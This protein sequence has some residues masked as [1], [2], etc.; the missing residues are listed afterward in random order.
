MRL[1]FTARNRGN[2][3]EN[4]TPL[5]E[6]GLQAEVSVLE[7]DGTPDAPKKISVSIQNMQDKAWE[8]VIVTELLANKK[9]PEFF[10]PGF[11]YGSNRGDCPQ[12][13]DCEY[14]RMREGGFQRP[15]S[16]FWMMRGDRLS[17]PVALIYDSGH[18]TGI[19]GN[20]YW[21]YKNGKKVPMPGKDDFYQYAGY[22]CSLRSNEADETCSVGYTL[23]YENAPLLFVQS[24]T[25]LDREPLGENCFALAAGETVTFELYVFEYEAEDATGIHKA[26]KKVYDLFHESPRKGSSVKQ[27]VEDLS[28]AIYRCSYLPEQK[29]Y[30]LFVR[31]GKDG[32]Y[33]YHVLGSLSWTN[34]LSVAVPVLL[35]AQ[36][37]QD[38]KMRTQAL[39][40][41]GNILDNCM[42]P[43]S[44]LPYDAVSDGEWSVRGWWFD[45]M[46]TPGH[47]GYLTGQAMYYVLKAYQ[48]EKVLLG[49]EHK[50]WLE[51]VR[52]VLEKVEG[53]KN[54]EF[55]YPFVFSEKT[56]AGLE[57]DSF[58]GCWCLAAAA[59]YVYLTGE[60]SRLEGLLASEKHYY[61]SY[62]KKVM[63]YGAPLDTDKAVDSEGVLAYLRAVRYLHAITGEEALLKHMK[64]ALDYEFTYK[65]CYNSPIKVPPLSTI[66]WSSCGGSITSTCNPHI[67]PMSST[68]VD[69]MLY[70]VKQT[71]DV[72]VQSRME[73]TVKWGCQTYNTYDGEYGYGE[74]GW[75]SERF[76]YSQGLVVEKYP[77][78]SPASTWFALMPWASSSVIEGLVGDYWKE[79]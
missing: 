56:G 74:K 5:S 28:G 45:G 22:T 13:V 24:H 52:P 21:T 8:G 35:A 19:C 31:N 36:R 20:P 18:I 17:A 72:Y 4:Y 25:V 51:F 65:F 10:L 60:N 75:M 71:G 70:Y 73:D 32:G 44:G 33:D 3:T 39:T 53:Q 55:E 40:V 42:N 2:Q 30:S 67:H 57:Y 77:D 16:S 41:I 38:E 69:E 59:Y 14:P 43:L 49:V 68:V 15:S 47:S 6:H 66:G 64:D 50:E 46:H 1:I 7:G 27:T 62:V 61:E 78:G 29:I 9:A 76:C 48:Y 79:L 58:G 11:M 37:M 12:K 26:V 54:T 34:G 63:C 23:G